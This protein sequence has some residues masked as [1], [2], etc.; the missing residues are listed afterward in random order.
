MIP[1]ALVLVPM[2]VQVQVQVLALEVVLVP[3][4]VL[5][6][7]LVLVARRQRAG[8]TMTPHSSARCCQRRRTLKPHGVV[9]SEQ[10][11]PSGRA[12]YVN[13]HSATLPEQATQPPARFATRRSPD[14]CH[15]R[16]GLA[17]VPSP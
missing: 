4:L 12:S 7:V 8:I 14:R 2:L 16:W 11:R 9:S 10:V 6:L 1:L 17:S 13:A 15:R 5:V 3:V